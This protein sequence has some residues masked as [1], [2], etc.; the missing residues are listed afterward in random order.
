MRIS[1]LLSSIISNFN[2]ND[3]NDFGI[4]EDINLIIT[5][6]N[7]KWNEKELNEKKDVIINRLDN[8]NDNNNNNDKDNLINKSSEILDNQYNEE[9]S[10][11]KENVEESNENLNDDSL[12]KKNVKH[13]TIKSKRKDINSNTKKDNKD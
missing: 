9:R 2:K 10:Q 3:E 4:E 1:S 6:L 11:D 12:K 5:T 7:E 13:L 8:D